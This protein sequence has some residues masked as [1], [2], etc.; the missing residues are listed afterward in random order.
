MQNV[1]TYASTEASHDTD[2]E[3]TELHYAVRCLDEIP[4]QAATYNIASNHRS[5]EI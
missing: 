4:S 5:G 3:W 1:D 2:R